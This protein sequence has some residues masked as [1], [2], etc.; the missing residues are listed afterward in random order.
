[1]NGEEKR[2]RVRGR[3]LSEVER[4]ER[5][6]GNKERDRRIGTKKTRVGGD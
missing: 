6:E 1:M 2:G 4:E 5:R 3:K